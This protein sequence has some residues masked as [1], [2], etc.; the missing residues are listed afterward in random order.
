MFDEIMHALNESATYE[1][2]LQWF[3]VLGQTLF[4]VYSNTGGL[5]NLYWCCLIKDRPLAALDFGREFQ[6]LQQLDGGKWI[7][8]E[9]IPT[10]SREQVLDKIS[11]AVELLN[12]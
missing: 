8:L 12:A 4:P 6:G 3:S 2:G 7:V 5:Q 11:K 9:F 10:A 1:H